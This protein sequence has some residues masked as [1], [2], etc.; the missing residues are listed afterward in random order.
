MS[1]NI[2]DC[3][4]IGIG[5]AKKCLKLYTSFADSDI[6]IASPLGLRMVIAD[7]QSKI[8]IEKDFLA[9]IE[10]LII[11]KVIILYGNFRT[12]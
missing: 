2:D 1:G 6:I 5:F 11:D 9:S 7:A 12:L 4:R 3:F 10:I 8:T